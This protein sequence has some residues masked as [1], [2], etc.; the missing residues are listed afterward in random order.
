MTKLENF[1]DN[2]IVKHAVNSATLHPFEKE[3]RISIIGTAFLRIITMIVSGYACYHFYTVH[4]SGLTSPRVGIILSIFICAIV[5]L[6]TGYFILKSTKH[7]LKGLFLKAIFPFLAVLIC[8]SLSFLGTT[9]GLEE[10]AMKKNDKSD[11]IQIKTNANIDSLRKESIKRIAELQGEIETIKKNPTEWQGGQRVNL[12]AEQQKQIAEYSKQIDTEKSNLKGQISIIE[13][14][15]D[16]SISKTKKEA[17]KAG[18]NYF[19][20]GIIILIFQVIT[21][22]GLAFF[23]E[24]IKQER[25]KD[26]AFAESV[27]SIRDEISTQ[28]LSTAQN[29]A[30]ALLSRFAQA[31]NVPIIT[32]VQNN[33]D[34]AGGKKK[35]P[36]QERKVIGGF[37]AQMKKNNG[38]VNNASV[39]NGKV[40]ICEHCGD[41][42]EIKKRTD[43]RFCSDTC[44]YAWHKEHN[45]TDV[46]EIKKRKAKK[47]K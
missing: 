42:F 22:F 4:I 47:K 39:S 17:E 14:K 10:M 15:T 3:W 16:N 23:W 13:K 19:L 9:N 30:Y 40:R 36:D 32:P 41:E 26:K 7:V 35:E 6:L 28:I 43:K 24:K 8:F 11:T 25:E 27:D 34:D 31:L 18:N 29:Q 2:I 5:E 33:N 20:Y 21:G 46:T 12:S 44:R 45:G 38:C 1:I 37:L